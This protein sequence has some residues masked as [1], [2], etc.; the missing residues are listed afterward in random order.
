MG[1]QSGGL[2]YQGMSGPPTIL[3]K[4][5]ARILAGAVRVGQ[6]GIACVRLATCR[7]ALAGFYQPWPAKTLVR[8]KTLG[9]T[10]I[11]VLFSFC[12]DCIQCLLSALWRGH[13]R[14]IAVF[15]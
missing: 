15:D 9:G 12:C 14:V 3:C 1:D 7:A 4:R 8:A 5:V 6:G 11:L 13:Y 10:E 2:H